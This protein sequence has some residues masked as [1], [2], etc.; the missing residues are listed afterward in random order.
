MQSK[1]IRQLFID[2]FKSKG[3]TF[4]KPSPIIPQNDPTLLFINAGMNQFK[5]IFL[6]LKPAKIPRAVNSQACIRVSGKHN[7][8]EEVGKDLTHL[9][10]FEMLGNWS[11]N[12]YYKKEAIAWAWELLTQVYKIPQKVLYATVFETDDESLLLWQKETNIDQSHI[13]KCGAKDNFWEMAE[14]GPCGPCSEIHLDRG[15]EYCDKK[16]VSGHICKVNGD[17]A[18]FIEIWNLVFIQFNR[19]KDGSLQDLPAR[20]VDT[21][22]GLE[23]IAA[24]LQDTDSN[25]RTDLLFPLIQKI[26][27]LSQVEYEDNLSGMPHRVMADHIRTI[28]FAIADNVM[29]SNEGR[30]YVIRR[31]LRRALRY[32]QKINLKKPVLF[33]LVDLV[34]EIMQDYSPDII[35]R[36]EFIK[37]VVKAEEISF[38]K[39]LEDGVKLFENII[40]ELKNKNLQII[41]GK[42]AFKL[43]DTYGF[44]LDLTQL[45]AEEIGFEVDLIEFNE[46]LLKQKERSRKKVKLTNLEDNLKLK[47][48]E[49]VTPE[50]EEETLKLS[51]H[52]TATHL[53]QAG[54]RQVLGTH[55]YQAGSKVDFNELRFDFSHFK[56]MTDEEIKKVED[57]VNEI[58][59]K[60]LPVQKY[61]TELNKAKAEG[62]MSL[63]GEKYEELVR[64]VKVGDFSFE[65]CGGHHVDNT[66][67]IEGVKIISET[68]IAAGTRRITAIAGEENILAYKN[69]KKAKLLDE[70]NLRLNEV[71]KLLSELMKLKPEGIVFTQFITELKLTEANLSYSETSQKIENKK[72]FKNLEI[73]D[74]IS[75]KN[76]LIE[77]GKKFEKELANCKN[78]QV[79]NVFNDVIKEIKKINEI[80]I[81]QK[82][83]QGFD[84]NQLRNI[85][86]NLITNYQNL[87]C[88]LFTTKDDKTNLL[89]RIS[90][91]LTNKY[92]AVEILKEIVKIT[93]GNG[94][95]KLGMA[96][97][98]GIDQ[99][100]ICILNET[101][102]Y[103]KYIKK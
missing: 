30:G 95:G 66:G 13:I 71:K 27:Q 53:L 102:F 68:G 9:T 49:A 23:R 52:H 37:E 17:C 25:Y 81:L 10:F 44:P 15:A 101:D 85:S 21:G 12:D 57:I 93:G 43:Y 35:K 7:D 62:A 90:D 29:P 54:L 2:F 89:V 64:V 76:N 84:I 40:S 5:E 16:D 60:N 55:V 31:L 83:F 100:K 65:L 72:D 14:T 18:R 77:K 42:T 11:F 20:H 74:L 41:N 61:Q 38:L 19:Q 32:A 97:A 82:Y 59:E 86:D 63:F 28:S 22:A 47:G 88:I 33:E 103:L 69:Q 24:I 3:H 51:R 96:Q 87:I 8:L 99:S 50:N 1:E 56:P 75:L 67:A 6:G 34:I 78:N 91:N 4:I 70:I 73:L 36:K 98:G 92:S 80:N 46:E 79:Q 26:E 45:M 48:G 94:G 58:I 39:T